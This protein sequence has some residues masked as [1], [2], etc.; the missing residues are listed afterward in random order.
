MKKLILALSL[1]CV[2]GCAELGLTAS[3]TETWTEQFCREDLD[4]AARVRSRMADGWEYE[5]V[6]HPNGMNCYVILFTR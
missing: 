5:G 1:V 3:P 2:S 6:L 4:V